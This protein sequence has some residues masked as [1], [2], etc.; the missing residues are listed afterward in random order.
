MV[1]YPFV[2]SV[3][4]L[5]LVYTSAAH[6]FGYRAGLIAAALLGVTPMEL[7]SATKLLP[8]MPAAFYAALGVTVIAL[9]DR[10][11]A[12][13]RSALFWGGCLGGVSFGLSWLC[14]EAIS[15][16]A[17]FC[18]AYMAISFKGNARRALFL[19]TGVAAGALGV[20]LGEMVAYLS[21]T[22][23]PLFRFR[24]IERNY[25]ELENGFFTEGSDFGWQ[26][27]ESYARAFAKR[28]LVSGPAM[29]LLDQAFLL[30]P[31][32]GLIA[33]FHGWYSKDRS[34]LVPS[35]W[36]VTLLLMFNFASTS[37]SSYMPIALFHRYFHMIIFPSVVLVAGLIGKLVFEGGEDS[38]EEVRRERRF[39]GALLAIGLVLVGG[40]NLQGS[41][42]SSPS[43][44]ASELRSLRSAVE[45][46]SRLYTDTLSIRGFEFLWGYPRA[47][48]WTDFA[49]L[50]S[51]EEVRPGSLVLVNRA[52]IEWLNRNGGMWLSP[53]SGYRQH[54]FYESP[55]SSWKEVW[56]NGNVRMYRAE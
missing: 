27:G 53:R 1:L 42:R 20:L 39:W 9:V 49:D 21:V 4:T 33:A 24:E 14:K 15:F 32:I 2:L 44:W 52:Y 34:L 30:L 35:L 23:D 28:L 10:S 47:T 56:R 18:L 36:L 8:D 41:L 17:P 50:A 55:P 43:S 13:R 5:L 11:A 22:G 48:Q 54:G 45:P 3:F 40:Y 29:L 16:L 7:G 51:S 26:E 12:E 6:F 31:M 19:W 38:Q 46:S 25:R 37:L